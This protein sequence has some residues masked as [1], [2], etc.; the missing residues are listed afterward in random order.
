MVAGSASAQ[1]AEGNI[2]ED[3]ASQFLIVYD[4]SNS[5]WGEL[6]DRS[7]KYEAGRAALAN[8]LGGELGERQI[9]FRAYGHRRKNDCRDSELVV[10]FGAASEAK[11]PIEDAVSRIRP[12][13]KTPITYSLKEG[14]K[15]F[16][17]KPGDILLI[18]DGIET[19]DADPC[20]LMREWKA[21]NVN[22]RVHV[23]GVGLND[24]ERT[25][26]S[27]IA[28]ESGGEYFDADTAEGF[29]EALSD[30]SVAIDEPAI[31]EASEPELVDQGIGYSLL[32]RAVDGE[33]R[34]YNSPGKLFLNGEEVD[35]VYSQGYGRNVVDGPGD[36]EIEIGPILQDGTIFKPVRQAVSITEPGRTIV[37]VL[38]EAPARVSAK[39]IEDGEVQ[40]GS[41]VTAYQNGEE[42]FTFRAKDEVLARAGDY[43]FKAKPNQDNE[44]S[45]TGILTENEHTEIVFDL[46]KTVTF[47]VEY[48][49]P[50]GETFRR[51]SRLWLDGEEVYRVYSGNPSRARPGVYELHSD[52]QNLP[53][54]P[55]DIEITT[56]GETITVPIAAGWVKVSYAPSDYNYTAEPNRAWIEA[57]DRGGS[58]YARLDVLIPVTPGH[59][60]IK[61]Q[62]SKGFFDRPEFDVANGET[63]DVAVTPEPVGELVM[64]Y[65]PSDRYENEPDRGSA[66][67]L[68][69]QRIIGGILRPGKVR[70]FLPGRYEIRGY[71]H[72]GDIQSQEVTIVAGQRTEVIL[73][74]ANN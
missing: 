14:L 72:A 27:C 53:L 38:V 68:E 35:V 33:G 12:T 74:L 66:S 44:L 13:G 7:R 64:T 57:I 21:S 65:A 50:N 36:Y 11:T 4:S 23:V 45:V 28:E 61:A 29:E 41:H 5:M 54:T 43:E 15:D 1:G 42:V 16:S 9:G 69:G 59:Y 20:D 8:F 24:M 60:A 55:V 48:E 31:I 51:T 32:I 56:D 6:A 63:V 18:S 49:L 73:E 26:M 58:K 25:A 17:G 2:V 3:E 37:D 52:D 70:K 19:C 22:I 39:F 71:S 10:P 67:A 62:D 40:P 47:Y 30:A 46:T 34:S